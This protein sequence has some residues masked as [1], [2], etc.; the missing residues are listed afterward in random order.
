MRVYR[1]M[2]I[3]RLLHAVVALF[4]LVTVCSA[5]EKV[6]FPV[7]VGTKTLG[8]GLIWLAAKKGFFDDLGL[9]VQ[10]ILLRGT[11]IAVQALVGES[12]YVSLGSADAMV[13]AAVG[14]ADLVS[15]AGVVNG[16]TQ[17]I[18]AGK[19]YRS[20]KELRGTTVGVQSLASGA[21]T[22]LKRIFKKNGIDYP[23]DY[24]MLALG[25]GNFNLA[26]LISGQVSAAFLVVPLV[27]IAE[28][29]GLNVLAYYKDYFPNY[30][31]TVM[32]VKRSWAEKNRALLVRFLRGALRANHWLLANKEAASEFLAQE[33]QIAPDL[34]RKGWDY[35]TANRIWH[36]SLEINSEGMKLALEI[37]AEETKVPTPD[38]TKYI[39]RSFLH[40]AL[41]Q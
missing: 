32:S 12:L 37:L 4:L 34:A 21:T 8:T 22:V 30:Q 10:P 31:L 3:S 23:A 33:I 11:P 28:Q 18:V 38:A 36:P 13:S 40:Q 5:Q 25:G 15:V 19:R 26:A 2:V 24:K 29:Q 14:G 20:F 7:G 1:L 17:A 27:F 16:L 9:E 41:S 35:Y 39:D 6:K